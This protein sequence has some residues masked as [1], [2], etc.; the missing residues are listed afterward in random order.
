MQEEAEASTLL[1]LTSD[2]YAPVCLTLRWSLQ[3]EWSGS[4]FDGWV[5]VQRFSPPWLT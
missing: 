4:C 5:P 3:D 2:Q 1:G